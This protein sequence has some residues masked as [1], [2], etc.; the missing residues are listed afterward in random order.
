MSVTGFMVPERGKAALRQAQGRVRKLG[1]SANGSESL[2]LRRGPTWET[3]PTVMPATWD[4]RG[5][6]LDF[7]AWRRGLRRVLLDG[8]DIAS[9]QRSP[10]SQ[11]GR[12]RG[13]GD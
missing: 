2:V 8:T 7:P 6:C 4:H 10:G 3:V 5:R 9:I 12:E 13:P 11:R 1:N